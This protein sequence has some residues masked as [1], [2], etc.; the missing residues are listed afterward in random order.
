M[1]S[2]VPWEE[3]SAELAAFLEDP[4]A[5]VSSDRVPDRV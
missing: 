2:G 3:V 4:F 5:P 1:T